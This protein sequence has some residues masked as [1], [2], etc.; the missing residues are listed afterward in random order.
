MESAKKHVISIKYQWKVIA[1]STI[2]IGLI[3]HFY[4]FV[5][6]FLSSDAIF[7]VQADQNMITS[8]RWLL[9]VACGISSDYQLPWVIGCLSLLWLSI[10]GI[11]LVEIF[12]IK[13]SRTSILIAGL[14][15][16]FPALTSTFSYMYTADGYMLA[17]MLVCISVFLL[18]KFKYGFI[19]GG[20][21][22][23]SALGIYQAYLAFAII[24][25]IFILFIEL[26]SSTQEE[27]KYFTKQMWMLTGKMT[28]YGVFGLAFYYGMLQLLLKIQHTSLSTYQGINEMTTVSVGKLPSLIRASYADFFSFAIRS[29]ILANNL[30]SGF[31]IAVLFGVS[32]WIL[33]RQIV[34]G[35]VFQKPGRMLSMFALFLVLPLAT[36]VILLIS[37]QAFNHLVMRYHWAL[38]LVFPILLLDRFPLQVENQKENLTIQKIGMSLLIFAAFLMIFNN[39]LRANIAYFNMNERYEKTYAYCIRLADRMEETEGYYPGIPIMIIGVISEEVYP[40]TDITTEVTGSMIGVTGSFFLYTGEQYRI[41]FEH[42]LA[43][44]FHVISSEEIA[45]IYDTE[46]YRELDTFPASNSMKVVDGILYIKTEP[47]E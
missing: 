46:E 32:I 1:T 27:Q 25:C 2:V 44:P 33:L 28:A 24:L 31:A 8:G 37:D 7:N 29:K 30:I 14:L 39:L 12:E 10:S 40:D 21:L 5:H 22:L 34:K 20:I 47:S 36:N 45:R 13:N 6:D 43:V 9:R 16:S 18:K 11:A 15:V 41:F 35:K 3:T 26:L 4:A 42:Y 17:V 19:A 23:G 38:F